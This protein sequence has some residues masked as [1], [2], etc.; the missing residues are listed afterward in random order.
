MSYNRNILMDTCQS[1]VCQ[2]QSAS[3]VCT[4]V[5]TIPSTGVLIHIPKSITTPQYIIAQVKPETLP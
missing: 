3:N 4:I 1:K 2:Q 5:G